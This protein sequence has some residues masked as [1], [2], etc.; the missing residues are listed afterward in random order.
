MQVSLK[1]QSAFSYASSRTD[2]ECP[3]WDS[4]CEA[5]GTCSYCDFIKLNCTSGI[6]QLETISLPSV[7]QD[8]PV[9]KTVLDLMMSV[10]LLKT[11][12][13]SFAMETIALQV[14]SFCHSC[15]RNFC[16]GCISNANCPSLYPKCGGGGPNLCGCSATT[17]CTGHD[18]L[19]NIPTYDNCFWCA[20]PECRMG[21]L[22]NDASQFHFFRLFIQRQLP[23]RSPS[24]RGRSRDGERGVAHLRL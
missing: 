22:H 11:Q 12:T 4:T 24:L 6:C 8:V 23:G 7:Y 13:A 15:A 20:G 14:G 18:A 17:D 21:K 5:R 1:V 16:S 3:G 19:C 10:I 2:P 9:T